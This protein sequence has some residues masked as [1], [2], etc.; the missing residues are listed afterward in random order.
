MATA[1]T[2]AAHPKGRKPGKQSHEP[3]VADQHADWVGLLRPDGPFLSVPAL[4]A[5]FKQGL[6]TVPKETVERIRQAWIEVNADPELLRSAWIDLILKELLALPDQA[7]VEGAALP[8]ALRSGAAAQTGP[9]AALCGPALPAERK[10]A[11]PP[12]TSGAAPTGEGVTGPGDRPVRL[13]IYRRPW[14]ENPTRSRGATPSLVDQAASACREHG[15]PLALLTNGRLFVLVHARVSEP[16]TT[17]VFD[18]DLWLEERS[19]LRAFASLLSLPRLLRPPSADDEPTIAALA[20][21]FARTA[22][23][24]TEVTN[25]L[26]AQVRAAVELLVAELSRLDRQAHSALLNDVEPQTVYRGALTVM[27][28]LVFLLY[29]EEQRLLPVDDPV[30]AQSYSVQPLFDLLSQETPEVGFTRASAWPRLIAVFA[31]IHGGSTHPEMRIPAYGGTL[32]D[33]TRYPWLAKAMVSNH[34]VYRML[35]A[36]LELRRIKGNTPPEKLS[37]KGLDVTQIGHV[38]EGLLEHS[39]TRTNEA[40]VGLI[41]KHTAEVAVDKLRSE[42]VHGHA[43]L[44]GWL[45]GESGASKKVIEDGLKHEPKPAE[46]AAL[47]AACDNDTELRD[48]L[49]PYVGILRKDL[50][51]RPTVFPKGSVIITRSGD[52][53]AFGTH[54]TPRYLAEEVVQHTLD[55]LCYAPGPAEGVDPKPENVK[56]AEDLLELKILDPAVGSGAFLVAACE[57]L[58]GRVLEAWTRDGIPTQVREAVSPNAEHD[59]LHLTARRLVASRCLHGVDQDDAAIEL[60]KLSLWLVTLAKDRPFSFLDHALRVG[61]SL[62]GVTS[63]A[64]IASFHLD[65]ARGRN[66]NARLSGWIDERIN[67]VMTDMEDLRTDIESGP[68]DDIRDVKA[69]ERSLKQADQL[70]DS[71]RL[72]A[73]GI[74]AAALGSAG[75]SEEAFDAR[76]TWLAADVQ[77]SLDSDATATMAA[78]ATVDRWLTG[79]ENGPREAPLRPL[80]WPLEFPEV[81]KRGGFD[82]VVGNPPFRGAT[83]ISGALGTDIRNYLARFIAENAPSSGRADLVSYFLLRYVDLCRARTGIISTKTIIETDSREISIDRLYA[84][85]LEIYRGTSPIRW[86]HQAKVEFCRIWIGW[87]GKLESRFL[88]D[89]KV[90][91]INASLQVGGAVDGQPRKLMANRAGASKGCEPNGDGFFLDT[92]EARSL[93]ERESRNSAVVRKFINGSELNSDPGPRA[94][95][96]VIFFQD[97]TSEKAEVYAE[98]WKIVKTR[99][100]PHRSASIDT[101]Y[102]GLSTRW[103]QFWRP[104]MDLIRRV[105]NGDRL[106]AI[107]RTSSTAIPIFIESTIIPSDAVVVFTESTDAQLAILSSAE[108]YYWADRYSSKMK[109]DLRYSSSDAFDPFPRPTP[110]TQLHDLGGELDKSRAAVM[111][112]RQAG[113]TTLYNDFH[114]PAISDQSIVRLRA[115][116]EKIDRAVL[117]AYALDED[118]DSDIQGFEAT[119]A[120]SPLP[121]WR[122][123]ELTHDFYP[124]GRGLRFTVNPVARI[125]ILDKLL[126]LNLYRYN[127]EYMQGLHGTRSGRSRAAKNSQQTEFVAREHN[128]SISSE[129]LF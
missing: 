118:R 116:H 66:L 91:K 45:V 101:T 125:A 53:R 19:L 99:V 33:S 39:S 9:D 111:E 119:V 8:T 73:D 117:E 14:D 74:A 94:G 95:R 42:A 16:T 24:R 106:L 2:S 61:D 124:S 120:S 29:A 25:T 129:T 81:V 87:P 70:A 41:G 37:Y 23:E 63:V 115:I 15:V 3:T 102:P 44:V 79:P 36:L 7:L 78:R 112:A 5:A 35:A 75:Q 30:Y 12:A 83:Y 49:A 85:G 98:C 127:Q 59:E 126:A 110:T 108:H 93:I 77:K 88:D 107:S 48:R 104:R 47:H 97:W 11:T 52:R 13:L 57:Y 32:F 65:P 76:L 113:L 69:K 96:W 60:A 34:V 26:G 43:H 6:D 56:K 4:A 89:Q 54:Y 22:T 62:V 64:Q 80:H 86:P 100:K 114:S 17:A 58:A 27:M 40:H 90:S 20:E 10:P 123:I 92:T 50:R 55:P 28:R 103:W 128:A 109:R 121:Q 72:V 18:A 38:Y 31:A 82:A 1:G 46:I 21:L 105:S 122:S 71:I 51:G 84:R 67:A 68:A